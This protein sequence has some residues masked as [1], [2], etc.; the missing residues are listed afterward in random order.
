M[1]WTTGDEGSEG[2]IGLWV[3]YKGGASIYFP[4]R[5]YNLFFVYLVLECHIVESS[6]GRAK[7]AVSI[8]ACA[9]VWIAPSLLSTYLL[10]HFWPT[11]RGL[12]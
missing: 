1:A 11:L 10:P 12:W 8:H 4:W 2:H 9:L 6:V 3:I 5:G 7:I